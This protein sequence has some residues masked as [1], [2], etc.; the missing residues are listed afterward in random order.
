MASWNFLGMKCAPFAWDFHFSRLGALQVP[1]VLEDGTQGGRHFGELQEHWRLVIKQSSSYPFNE[2]SRCP[3]GCPTNEQFFLAC[4]SKYEWALVCFPLHA[5]ACMSALWCVSPLHAFSR[6][7][8][9]A[10]FLTC[11][12][13]SALSWDAGQCTWRL[14]ASTRSSASSQKRWKA[15]VHS[16]MSCS[17]QMGLSVCFDG[18]LADRGVKT[19]FS[20]VCLDAL[21]CV[22]FN[23]EVCV[24]PL[25]VHHLSDLHPSVY[26]PD[27]VFVDNQQWAT[28]PDTFPFHPTHD[29]CGVD[30]WSL[31]IVMWE[32][33]TRTVPWEGLN[34]RWNECRG[35]CEV[36]FLVKGNL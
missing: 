25:F 7:K 8:Q 2:S 26:M 34:V 16:S 13:S 36:C 28:F 4:G 10:L 6:G 21:P 11:L 27:L 18:A 15:W 23:W 1:V 14:S 31:A 3:S 33:V 5:H 30:I 35:S 19:A 22:D 32:L 24:W 9:S 20:D 12:L 29:A 17:A